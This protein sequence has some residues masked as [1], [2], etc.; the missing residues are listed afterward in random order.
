MCIYRSLILLLLKF[1]SF[2]SKLARTTSLHSFTGYL[3]TLIGR[4]LCKWETGCPARCQSCCHCWQ[5]N[6]VHN[7]Q[8]ASESKT[9]PRTRNCI[10]ALSSPVIQSIPP[11]HLPPLLVV[12]CSTPIPIKL[13]PFS[14]TTMSTASPVVIAARHAAHFKWTTTCASARALCDCQKTRKSKKKNIKN[15]P[16]KLQSF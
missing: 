6:L 5:F 4:Q 12:C 9:E 14:T 10:P 15:K 16:K 11:F 3:S 13:L 1:T 8:S 2:Y 7:P